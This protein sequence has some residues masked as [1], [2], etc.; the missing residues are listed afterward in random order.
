MQLWT[1]VDDKSN[2]KTS[3][4]SDRPAL[5]QQAFV[6]RYQSSSCAPKLTGYMAAGSAAL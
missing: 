6:F 2:G 4:A 5:V 1:P 3:R